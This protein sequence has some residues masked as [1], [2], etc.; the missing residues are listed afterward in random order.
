MWGDLSG[1]NS[2]VDRTFGKGRI[3][4]GETLSTVISKLEIQ[5]DF[6]WNAS[7]S[8]KLIFIHKKIGEE[9]VYYVANQEENSIVADCIFR[10]YGKTPEIWDPQHG[11]VRKT[12][13][14]RME[15]GRTRMPVSF[16]PRQ[17]LLFIFRKAEPEEFITTL[18]SENGPIYPA[19]G[20][21]LPASVPE[22]DHTGSGY[23]LYSQESGKYTLLTSSGRS[24]EVNIP[25]SDT[26]KVVDEEMKLVFGQDSLIITNLGSWTELDNPAFKYF[27]GRATYWLD[28]TTPENWDIQHDSLYLS[29]GKIDATAKVNVNGRFIC[30]CWIPDFRI[31]VSGLLQPGKNVLEVEIANV[32]RNRIIGDLREYG[33]MENIWTTAPVEEFFNPEMKLRSSGLLGPVRLIRVNPVMISVRN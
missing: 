2:H 14:Y 27:S 1:E 21:G 24:I 3:M 9:D 23:A 18:S 22:I 11:T 7:D 20:P 10:I 4:W 33:R 16:G 31:P 29:L 25:G 15:N 30:T 12:A 13:L 28:F 8:A 5:P 26:M 6:E 17:S 32:Y 19:K